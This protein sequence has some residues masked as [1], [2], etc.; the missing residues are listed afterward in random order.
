MIYHIK[1]KFFF[2]SSP[3]LIIVAFAK[4]KDK[5]L[6]VKAKIIINGINNIND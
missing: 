6:V 3:T 2:I 1:L 5:P 4:Y